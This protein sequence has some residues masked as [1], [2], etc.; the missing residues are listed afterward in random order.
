[1]QKLFVI[2]FLLPL[3]IY[4]QQLESFMSFASFNSDQGP[5]LETYLSFN[6]NTLIL[7]KNTNNLYNGEV[8]I[9]ITLYG[10][11]DQVIFH[12]RYILESPEYTSNMNN[13]IFFIDQQRIKLNDGGYNL[14]IKV[15]DVNSNFIKEHNRKINISYQNT[16]LSDI[17]LIDHY[18]VTDSTNFLTK[19]GYVLTPFVLDFYS[20]LL[21]TLSF[22]FEIL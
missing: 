10:E 19:S 7:T 3:N 11:K 14:I 13:N 8:D 6:V 18:Y 4:S 12:D 1:M 20:D 21:D 9:S 15:K 5:F 22:Y 17:Q 2:L 16:S